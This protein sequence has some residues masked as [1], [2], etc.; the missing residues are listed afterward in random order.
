M[1]P[2]SDSMF[3]LINPFLNILVNLALAGSATNELVCLVLIQNNLFFDV[4]LN[5]M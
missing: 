5:L 4:L 2:L 1:S 3:F